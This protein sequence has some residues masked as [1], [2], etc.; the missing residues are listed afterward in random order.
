MYNVLRTLGIGQATTLVLFVAVATLILG[1]V[2][3][4]V[5]RAANINGFDPG[6]IMSDG[7]MS[8]KESMSIGQIQSFL[9]S[10]NACNNTNVYMAAWYPHLQY[11]IRDG[12]FL[13][14]AKDSFNGKSAAQIIWQ[15]GQDYNINPQ[16][17]MVL[18]EKEQGLV[19]DTWPNHVQYRS[20]T[21]YGC[22]DTAP[23]DAQYY[24]LENQLRQA[25][26]LFRNVLNGGWS[27][28]P[29]G[30]TYVRYNP[31]VSCGGSVVNIQNRATSALYRYT[32]YQPNQSA[33]NAGYGRGDDCGAYG[34]RNFWLLFTDWFGSTTASGFV[35]LDTPRWMQIKNNGVRKVEVY[36]GVGVGANLADKQQIRFVDKI[37]IRDKWYL[38]TEF[39]QKDS[40]SYAVSQDQIEEIPYQ[41]I[42]P[43]W[44]T[45][46]EDGNRSLPSSRTI[47]GD[48][49]TH[50]TSVKVVDQITVDGNIYYRTEFNRNH[51][52]P[53][54]I[55]SRF[56][57]SY[58]PIPLMTSRNFC[59]S[60]VVNKLNPQT[61]QVTGSTNDGI[62]MIQKKT[63]INGVWYY[64]S[65]KDSGT[66][67]FIDSR[68]LRDTCY[69]ALA[70]PRSMILNR[71]AI[72]INTFTGSQ[73]DILPKDTVISLSTKVFINNSW[74]F[75]TEFN[76]KNNTD[77]VIPA[78]AFN[79]LN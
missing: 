76:T 24:G 1:V 21:G 56:T 71:D 31:T 8:N 46:K 10:K 35:A 78:S 28:Y 27:N 70:G 50:G 69:I 6:N 16:M 64:Q 5:S 14:M 19:T 59:A 79:E 23:C 68:N 75:R 49:L 47:T 38:R 74:Y 40:G 2:Y 33:L 4:P 41:A 42:T 26:N 22:P 39:N 7:V 57:S 15:V 20:A 30:S 60:T 44:V 43:K 48:P 62:F 25:A 9:D 51:N 18:L 52:Q 3:A 61:G 53:V 29:V 37:F 36:S 45:L 32:P 77:A 67:N 54:G 63:L 17:L 11:S 66:Q 65:A 34:N 12:R 58:T 72:R 73:L 55:H 13:C